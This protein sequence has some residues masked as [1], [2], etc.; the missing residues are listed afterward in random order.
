MDSTST[1]NVKVLVINTGSAPITTER[2]DFSSNEGIKARETV[3]SALNRLG[4]ASHALISYKGKFWVADHTAQGNTPSKEYHRHE[5]R[6]H[7]FMKELA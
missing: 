7:P 2:Y 5:V 4:K 1:D 3:L 6:Y